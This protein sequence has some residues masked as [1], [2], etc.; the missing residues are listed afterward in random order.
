LLLALA[1]YGALAAVLAGV[2]LAIGL[3][4]AWFVVTQMFEFDWL[5]GWG[6]VLG[7]LGAGLALV[8]AFALAGALPLLRAKPAQALR[9]L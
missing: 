4:A 8:V 5:P 9:E 1:E 6:A 2:A 3:A 7:V